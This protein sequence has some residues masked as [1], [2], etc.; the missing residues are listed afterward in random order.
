MEIKQ[1][2]VPHLIKKALPQIFFRLF[3]IFYVPMILIGGMG[4]RS[5]AAEAPKREAEMFAVEMRYLPSVPLLDPSQEGLSDQTEVQTTL[6]KLSLGFKPLIFNQGD[7]L[8]GWGVGY[9]NFNFGYKHWNSTTNPARVDSVY[10]VG[11]SLFLSQKLP[12]PVWSMRVFVTP[13]FRSDFKSLTTKSFRTQGGLFFSRQIQDAIIG[14]GLVVLDNSGQ[15]KVFPGVSYEQ[16]W[17][18][19]RHRLLIRAPVLGSY[20]YKPR[21]LWDVS[22]VARMTGIVARIEEA[23]VNRGKSASYSIAAVGPQVRWNLTK[24]W[25]AV[26]ES[27][28]VYRNKFEIIDGKKKVRDYDMNQAWY[29]ST[30]LKYGF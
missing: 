29:F 28:W 26:F 11:L 23:G 25:L 6:V 19:G 12:S 3:N 5:Q 21:E 17:R 4:N 30:G 2:R 18:Q 14:L 8:I 9:E 1:R 10:N 7:T 16:T 24:R 20:T 15:I 27:G 22:L 13:G